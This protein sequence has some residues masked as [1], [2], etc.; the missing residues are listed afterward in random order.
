MS[1]KFTRKQLIIGQSYIYK[2]EE[3]TMIVNKEGITVDKVVLKNH[4]DLQ[5]FARSL[6]L[7]QKD[8]MML[9]VPTS[10]AKAPGLN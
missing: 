5:E 6:S 1:K 8:M 9:M 10:L 2:K 7:A 4:A 3:G